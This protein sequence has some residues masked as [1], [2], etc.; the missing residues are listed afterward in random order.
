MG[1]LQNI[2]RGTNAIFLYKSFYQIDTKNSPFR[3]WGGRGLLSLSGNRVFFADP[4]L[5]SL[6][7]YF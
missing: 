1:S 3:E 6:A 2:H 5:L 7:K 4:S